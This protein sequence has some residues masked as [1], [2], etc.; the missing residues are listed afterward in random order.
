NVTGFIN[1]EAKLAEKTVELL[2]DIA[3]AT[4]RAAIIF[5]PLTAPQASYYL[6][7]FEAAAHSLGVEPILAAVHDDADIERVIADLAR[8]PGGGLV[9]MTD[10]FLFLHRE[11]INR[12]AARYRV[13]ATNT[14]RSLTIDGGLATYGVD[15]IDL[16]RRAASYADR[17]LKGEKPANL[18]VQAPV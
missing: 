3:P 16:F 15:N 13:P 18:P 10:I 1:I 2:K 9:L 11:A 4:K 5:N 6:P 8:E 12:L 7:P 17:I 14:E